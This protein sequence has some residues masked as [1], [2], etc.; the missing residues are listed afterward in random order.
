MEEP[1]SAPYAV[2]AVHAVV[3]CHQEE[4]QAEFGND[5][6]SRA[7]L[8][9]LGCAA[10]RYRMGPGMGIFVFYYKKPVFCK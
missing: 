3:A 10:L 8:L 7:R 6:N 4:L 2:T 5:V 9:R 1:Q